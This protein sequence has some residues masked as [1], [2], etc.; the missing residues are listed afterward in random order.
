MK[1]YLLCFTNLGRVYWLEV[2][3]IP[4]LPHREGK[5]IVNLLKL[6]DE[7]V[8]TVIPIWEFR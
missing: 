2:Y 6:K 1:D 7:V 4:S 8:T 3:Q 5:P